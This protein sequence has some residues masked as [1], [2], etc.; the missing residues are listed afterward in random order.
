MN[1]SEQINELNA[2]LSKA[3]G[4]FP[5]IP[6]T[7]M[8]K[9]R[10]KSG[11]EYTY[12]YA[13]LADILLAVVPKLSENGLC[14][15]QPVRLAGNAMR[16]FTEVHHASGQWT[17]DDGL[18]LSSG[19]LPQE[20]GSEL[21]Y[22]KRYGA[23]GM[24]GIAPDVDDDAKMA[25]EAKGRKRDERYD[26]AQARNEAS[27][28]SKPAPEVTHPLLIT[29]E[30]HTRLRHALKENGKKAAE[31]YAFLELKVGSPIPASRLQDAMVWVGK[32]KSSSEAPKAVVYA[33]DILDWSEFERTTYI[34]NH[35]KD[36]NIILES[37]NSMIDAENGKEQ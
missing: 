31:L 14:L 20:F 3:Q 8:A 36:W 25:N 19:L 33:F 5:A 32:P 22:M 11:G 17:S 23:C 13:D 21:S 28:N 15:R 12:M 26:S 10:M 4:A 24:L 30:Q 16:L 27:L 1:Q 35:S 6:K 34:E 37:L 9:V 29:E 7:K 18:P 2:A